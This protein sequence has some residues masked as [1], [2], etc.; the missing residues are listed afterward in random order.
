MPKSKLSAFLSLLLVFLSGAVVGAFAYRA[1]DLKSVAAE[2]SG[3][4]KRLDPEEVRKRIVSDMRERIHLDDQQV[5]QVNQILDQTGDQ[6]RKI[7]DKANVAMRSEMKPVHD[8]Q[9]ELIN[10]LLREDQRSLYAAW[11]AEREAE[12]KRHEAE[13]KGR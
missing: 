11:Q 4:P 6:F 7:R 3:P 13:K 12:R 9:V 8:K 10:S 2:R 1:Y 5:A